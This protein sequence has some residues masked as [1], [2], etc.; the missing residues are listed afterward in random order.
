MQGRKPDAAKVIPMRGDVPRRVPDAPDW[1]SENGRAAWARLAPIMAAKSRLDP[2]YE[3]LFA[4]YC[5]AVGDF[6]SH[7]GDLAGFGTYFETET[8]AGKQEKKRAP[9]TQRQEALSNMRQIGALFGLSPVDDMRLAGDGQ[10]D[11][12]AALEARLKGESD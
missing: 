6:M 1:M 9:W 3:D 10:G 8:K 7:T 11:L 12:L 4:G 2:H 5:E